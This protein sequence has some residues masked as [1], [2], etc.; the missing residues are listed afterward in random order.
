MRGRATRFGWTI[1]TRKSKM[2]RMDSPEAPFVHA[3]WITALGCVL[4]AV[5]LSLLPR[6]G[7]AGWKISEAI[8]KAPFLDLIVALF[9]WIPWVI[10][11]MK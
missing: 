9:T 10:A 4:L 3:L 5:M 7:M 6:L 1:Q 2:P 8:T 11:A